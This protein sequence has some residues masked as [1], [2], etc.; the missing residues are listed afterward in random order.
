MCT[1]WPFSDLLRLAPG[2]CLLVNFD[3]FNVHI[4]KQLQIWPAYKQAAAVIQFLNWLA[5]FW[6][7]EAKWSCL[8]CTVS[9]LAEW[10][11]SQLNSFQEAWIAWKLY[12]L[13]RQRKLDEQT[14]HGMKAVQTIYWSNIIRLNSFKGLKPGCSE[15][16][17]RKLSTLY[18]LFVK[19]QGIRFY[20]LLFTYGGI[21]TLLCPLVIS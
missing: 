12:K 7:Y 4:V 6:L 19:E 17:D 10:L 3:D 18:V 11:G 16:M 15:I 14:A 1:C 5:R 8:D 13:A 20:T 2:W 21:T 9:K